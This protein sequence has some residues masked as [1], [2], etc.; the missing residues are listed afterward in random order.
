MGS[1]LFILFGRLVM[2]IGG[3]LFGASVSVL[4]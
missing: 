4:F 3:G 1:D 2:V